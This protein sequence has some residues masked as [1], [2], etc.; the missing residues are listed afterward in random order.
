M[1]E[2]L[3]CYANRSQPLMLLLVTWPELLLGALL[4]IIVTLSLTHTQ[5]GSLSVLVM[6][7]LERTHDTDPT[8]VIFSP[9][10]T[11]A[12][13]EQPAPLGVVWNRPKSSEVVR[14]RSESESFGDRVVRIRPES[15]GVIQSRPESFGVIRSRSRP[16]SS[17]V[18]R[19]R[20]KSSESFGVDRSRSHSEL[21][22]ID[23]S[24]P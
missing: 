17:G 14:S 4:C 22:R 7:Y 3:E 23:R 8:P 15:F 12:K 13:S 1:R 5:S 21:S 16:E 19:S 2:A 20:S 6:C 9:I 11:P 24:Q 10:L 18:V